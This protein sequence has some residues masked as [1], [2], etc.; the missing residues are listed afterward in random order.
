[1][2]R[3]N[4]CEYNFINIIILN[5]FISS[6]ACYRGSNLWKQVPVSRHCFNMIIECL[7]L[8]INLPVYWIKYLILSNA[9][10]SVL[11][12]GPNL[13]TT[14]GFSQW[15]I[16][17][18]ITVITI[19]YIMLFL[20]GNTDE[21]TT[22]DTLEYTWRYVQRYLLSGCGE[23][24]FGTLARKVQCNKFNLSRSAKC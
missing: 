11:E 5:Q 9:L 6:T 13:T 7:K 19:L 14:D 4:E 2:F 15:K 24:I 1:M 16:M 20:V 18:A 23:P 21:N 17:S 8:K 10:S 3:T 12:L 22:E